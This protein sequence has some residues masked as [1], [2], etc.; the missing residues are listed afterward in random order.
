M[1]AAALFHSTQVEAVGCF[2][3]EY[4]YLSGLMQRGF[5][6][7]PPAQYKNRPGP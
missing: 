5:I 1:H 3:S 7:I 2:C 6:S 4:D